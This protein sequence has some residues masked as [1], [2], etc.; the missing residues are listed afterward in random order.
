[1]Y[2]ALAGTS[3][4]TMLVFLARDNKDEILYRKSA[5]ESDYERTH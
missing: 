5:G 1:M 2:L 3:L 4:F